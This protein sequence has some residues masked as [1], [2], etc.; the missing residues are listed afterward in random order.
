MRRLNAARL[1]DEQGGVAVI[2]AVIMV[3]L[4]AA[5]ALAIDVGAM[6]AERAQLQ[7][8]ADAAALAVAGDCADGT[9][10]NASSIAQRYADAN[11]N[12]GASAVSSVDFPR[13]GTVSVTTA[14]EDAATGA[15]PLALTFAPLLG[16]ADPDL[17]A[18]ATASWGSPASGRADLPLAFAP[19]VFRLD[20]AIQVLSIHGD[21]G[22]TSCS[23]T[24]PSGQ[25]LP[26]GFGWLADPT[27]TCSAD[28]SISKN[29]PMAGDSGVSISSACATVLPGLADKTILL[30]VYGDISGTGGGSYRITGWAA[31]TVLGWNFS[32]SVTSYHNQYYPGATCTGSCKGLIGKFVRFV[33]FD[34]RFTMGGP[35]LGASVVRLTK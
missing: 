4:L 29:A 21:S 28:V 17:S 26:G 27:N 34:D 2:V 1:R 20:G 16:I 13:A 15:G 14:T 35:D 31:F 30:P 18:S 8:G 7:N 3:A 32:G 23:S 5:T 33:S 25:L 11:A 12:D 22:G 24:S 10:G 6:Y 9:C 19:C